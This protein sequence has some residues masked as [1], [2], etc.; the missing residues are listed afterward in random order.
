MRNSSVLVRVLVFG[1]RCQRFES[2]FRS[3]GIS[4]KIIMN[5]GHDYNNNAST[6]VRTNT[7]GNRVEISLDS[8]S[9]MVAQLV[10]HKVEALGVS[11]SS[12]LYPIL[13]F[14]IDFYKNLY[15]NI[16]IRYKLT[17]FV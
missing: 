15:Y 10:E 6:K 7:C 4:D 9:G 17:L 11:G 3:F 8:T 5:V 1:T 13:L 2:S 14:L 16:Y 12:P